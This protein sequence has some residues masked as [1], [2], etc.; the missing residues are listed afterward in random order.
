MKIKHNKIKNVGV[1]FELLTRQITTDTI[2]GVKNSPAIAIVKEYF[3]KDTHLLKE[4]NL[5]KALQ[6][7]KYKKEQQA[8]K[9]IDLVL[10]EFKKISRSRVKREKYNLIKEIKNNYNL[11]DFFKSRV[12]NYVLNASIYK[13]LESSQSTKIQNPTS[14]MKCRYTLLEHITNEAGL[15]NK[16]RQA[17]IKE[18]SKQD[19]DLRLLS[20]RILLE[21]FNDKY[22]KLS[23]KQ[24]NLLREYINNISN[25]STL[26]KYMVKE[27]GLIN[28]ALKLLN[29]KVNDKIV[30]IKLQEVQQQ[31]SIIPEDT[32]LRE[33]HLV[34]LM[35]SY[36]L[37][38]ELRNVTK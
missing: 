23:K 7:Q 26:K 9:F 11:E 19:K 20:Y 1:L 25:T 32:K 6:Q 16:K 18:Y 35:R 4:Y 2:N 21:K 27:I 17:I 3:N 28:K 37:I 34:S 5:Y 12:S 33:K 29:E 30:K 38:K 31:L 24:Q 13:L 10:Q 36:D 8:E 15:F 22:G 14:I